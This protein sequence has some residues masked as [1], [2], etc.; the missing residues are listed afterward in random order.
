MGAGIDYGMGCT[1]IDTATRIRFGVI[2][3]HSVGSALYDAQEF[4]YPDNAG[5]Y[6]EPIGWKIEDKEY[7][8]YDCLDSDVMIVKSPYYTFARYCSPCVP[9]AGN[10]NSADP[11]GVKTYCLG[12]DW[13]EGGKAPYPVYRVDTNELV[14]E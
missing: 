11:E 14:S 9:G 10:L 2:S 5:E 8:I 12:H 3:Q 6:D 7:E 13:F 4:I 1:N